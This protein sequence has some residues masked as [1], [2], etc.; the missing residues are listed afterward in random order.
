MTAPINYSEEPLANMLDY[1]PELFMGANSSE[2]AW[3]ITIAS[4]VSILPLIIIF[5]IICS[6]LNVWVLM[7]AVV[8]LSAIGIFFFS[9]MGLK[10]LQRYKISKPEGYYAIQIKLKMDKIA[11]LLGKK[12]HYITYVGVWGVDRYEI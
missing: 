7:F 6:V 4:A 1:E 8:P 9:I 12:P 2:V 11:C 3:I 5:T 10:R